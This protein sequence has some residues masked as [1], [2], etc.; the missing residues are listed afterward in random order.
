MIFISAPYSSLYR[1]TIEKRVEIITFYAG[2]LLNKGIV[3]ISPI[4]VGEQIMKHFN[5]PSDFEFWDKV[6]YQY[7][8]RS[9]SVHVLTIQGWKG[10]KGV[11]GEIEF[12][13]QKNIPIEFIEVH[14]HENGIYDF[15][16]D[17]KLTKREQLNEK[18]KKVKIEAKQFGKNL[19]KNQYGKE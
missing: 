18:L 4:L 8:E 12:A 15:H 6:C 19:L 16:E 9:S 3:S 11:T 17:E 14:D 13:R 2:Y 10:S 5:F 1:A 7:L